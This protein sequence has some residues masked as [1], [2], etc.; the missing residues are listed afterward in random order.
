MPF[1]AW[2]RRLMRKA[3]IPSLG[4]GSAFTQW[5]LRHQDAMYF[6]LLAAA[7]LTW[8][9]QSFAYAFKV[10]A[11]YWGARDNADAPATVAPAVDENGV[12]A[13]AAYHIASATLRHPVMERTVILLH[14]AWYLALLATMPF[15][16]AL[17]FAIASQGVAGFLMALAFGV[18]HNGMAVYD[19]DKVP[20][21]AE[22]QVGVNGEGQVEGQHEQRAGLPV[23]LPPFACAELRRSPPPATWW[24][25]RST[26]SCAAACTS[27]S[28]TTCSLPCHGTTW[29]PWRPWSR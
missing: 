10:S 13:K 6:P 28:S 25:R 2:S 23:R 19:A 8:S 17:A 24:T 21:F 9:L 11:L 20:G 4:M 29:A 18:G 16:H 1:L 22:L 5:W 12:P 7:R 15:T 27:R 3:T 14:W 26:P